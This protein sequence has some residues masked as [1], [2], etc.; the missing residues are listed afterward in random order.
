MSAY[1]AGQWPVGVFLTGDL[2]RDGKLDLIFSRD[3][4]WGVFLNTCQ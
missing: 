3:G 4:K 1:Q 2:N